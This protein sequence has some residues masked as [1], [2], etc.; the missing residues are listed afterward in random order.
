[1]LADPYVLFSDPYENR[2]HLSSV[3]G[4]RPPDRRTGRVCSSNSF[5]VARAVAKCANTKVGHR[6]GMDARIGRFA[7]VPIRVPCQRSFVCVDV[8]ASWLTANTWLRSTSTTATFRPS[9]TIHPL[10]H[11]QSVVERLFS[12]VGQSNRELLVGFHRFSSK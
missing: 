6:S 4:W 11:M 7:A 5:P 1:M 10:D 9:L 12:A 3:R 8:L 2:T